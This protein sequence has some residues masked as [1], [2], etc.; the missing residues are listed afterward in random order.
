MLKKQ[1]FDRRGVGSFS[2]L[3]ST[4]G[5]SATVTVGMGLA[6]PVMSSLNGLHNR[7]CFNALTLSKTKRLP[8]KEQYVYF[9]KIHNTTHCNAMLYNTLYL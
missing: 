4:G 3:H 7:S 5:L 8:R 1:T 2:L 9:N 6:A